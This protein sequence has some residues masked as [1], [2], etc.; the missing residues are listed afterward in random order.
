MNSHPRGGR[1]LCARGYLAWHLPRSTASARCELG[2]TADD[3]QAGMELKAAV[4]ALPAPGVMPDIQ[5]AIDY[6]AQRSGR[7]AGHCGLCWGGLLDTARCVHAH[8]PVGGRALLR[9][10][11]DNPEEAARQPEV[12]VLAHFGERDHWIPLDSVQAPDRAQPG[13]E[14]YAYQADHGFNCDQRGS[15]DE[16]AALGRLTATH[17]GVL[18]QAPGLIAPGTARSLCAAWLCASKH[19]GASHSTGK[20]HGQL[21]CKIKPFRGRLRKRKNKAR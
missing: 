16:A 12:P 17:A 19:G 1:P 4:E 9:R 21:H 11:Y 10:W 13:V 18:R 20:S 8:R 5:A 14:V 6:A 7:K 3:M 15:Y 2:Y